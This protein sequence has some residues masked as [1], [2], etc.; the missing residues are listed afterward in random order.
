MFI[1]T[2]HC[3]NTGMGGVY[4]LPY[5]LLVDKEEEEEQ[6]IFELTYV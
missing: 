3:A 6:F 2:L 5:V 4:E 1:P